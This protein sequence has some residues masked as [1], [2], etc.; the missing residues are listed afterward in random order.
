M[1]VGYINVFIHLG[2]NKN[3]ASIKKTINILFL[4]PHNIFIF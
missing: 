4:H 2:L 1:K 3:T